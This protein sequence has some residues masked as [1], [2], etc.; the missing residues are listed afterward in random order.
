MVG[1]EKHRWRRNRLTIV[2]PVSNNDHLSLFQ[3]Y[4]ALMLPIAAIRAVRIAF[5]IAGIE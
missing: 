2:L 5:G 1:D 3:G 4:L